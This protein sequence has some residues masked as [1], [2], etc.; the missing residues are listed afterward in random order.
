MALT[1]TDLKRK[2]S[3]N[4]SP[5]N[6]APGTPNDSLGGYMSSTEITDA[7]L[8]N[9]FDVI[10]GD[11]NLASDVEYRC[12]FLHNSGGQ[13]FIGA[14]V[15]VQSEAAGG[16]NVAIALAGQ[17]VV[18]ATQ[19]GTPQADRIANEGT[20]PPGETFAEADGEGSALTIGDI[21]GGSCIGIGFDALPR[22]VPP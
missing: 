19:A 21:A 9:L 2:L 14:K 12:F 3:V 18:P 8:N 6:S 15:W 10:T 11:E 7:T 20:A 1:V 4:T 16:A 13:I 5:G 17:G 22:M